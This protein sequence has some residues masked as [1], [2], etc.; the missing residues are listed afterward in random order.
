MKKAKNKTSSWTKKKIE[1]IEV[2]FSEVKPLEKELQKKADE[3]AFR[4]G[5]L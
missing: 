2:I 3:S 4:F 1:N 5:G